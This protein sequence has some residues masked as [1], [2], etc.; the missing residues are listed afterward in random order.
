MLSDLLNETAMRQKKQKSVHD[1]KAKVTAQ[2]G[3]A[4]AFEQKGTVSALAL[5][6]RFPFHPKDMSLGKLNYLSPISN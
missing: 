5:D 6:N 3:S 2:R 1:S 4:G